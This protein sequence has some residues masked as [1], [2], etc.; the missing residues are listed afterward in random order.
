MKSIEDAQNRI[1]KL[2]SELD[3]IKKN[4]KNILVHDDRK[5]ET[6]K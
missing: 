4:Q 5:D 3:Q 2:T 6:Q 1:V